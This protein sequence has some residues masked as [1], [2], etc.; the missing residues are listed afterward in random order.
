MDDTEPRFLVI[1]EVIKPHGVR[2]E[3]RVTPHTDNPQ[4]FLA[5]QR[6]FV[7]REDP[8]SMDVT[9]VRFH[10]NQ[11]LLSLAGVTTRDAAE[12]LRG[13][14][15]QVPLSE[16][17][18]LAEDEY[19]LYELEGLAVYADTGEHLGELVEVLETKANNVFVVRGERGEILLPDIDEVIREIDFDNGRITVHL[20]PGLLP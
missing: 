10:Q 20:L 11:V 17:V 16:A 14:W 4:R 2:G 6:V 9:A 5:L 13:A 8:Q 15:L 19:F 3:L 18:P 12:A 7:G 1:G